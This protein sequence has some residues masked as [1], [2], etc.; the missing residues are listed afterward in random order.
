M[1]RPTRA[2]TAAYGDAVILVTSPK[3]RPGLCLRQS[4]V[5]VKGS[6]PIGGGRSLQILLDQDG[7]WRRPPPGGADDSVAGTQ[8]SLRAGVDACL[9][10]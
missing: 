4:E 9:A 8:P 3:A 5:T 10:G 1:G 7:A 6:Q 2:V